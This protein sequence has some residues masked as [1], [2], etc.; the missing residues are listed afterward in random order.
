MT[1]YSDADL[2]AAGRA[3]AAGIND[4]RSRIEGLESKPAADAMAET[5][6]AGQQ[7]ARSKGYGNAELGQLEAF[8]AERGIVNRSDAMRVAPVQNDGHLSL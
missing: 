8:M 2:A 4:L 5:W 1:V 6:R 3:L 7:Y